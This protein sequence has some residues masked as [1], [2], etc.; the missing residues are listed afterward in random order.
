MRVVP[1]SY[2]SSSSDLIGTIAFMGAPTVSHELLPNGDE[3]FKSV[4]IIESYLSKNIVGIISGEIGGSNGLM[5]LLVAARKDILCLDADGM[6]R[7]FPCLSQFLPFINGLPP[8]PSCLCDVRGET[9]IGTKDMIST[10]Q[11]LEDFFRKECTQRG[12]SVGVAFPP[13]IGKQLQDHVVSYSLS[14]AW[15][16]GEYYLQISYFY[17][18]HERYFNVGEAKF[19]HRTNAIEAV[20]HAGHGR[21]LVSDGKVTNVER[22]TAAG[23]VRGHVSIETNG[24]TLIIEFQNENLLARY[25]DG[26]IVASTPDIITLV[27]Q[28]SA[29][30]LATEIVKY[31]YRVSVLVL[32]VPESMT[33]PQALNHVGLQAFKYNLE[34]YTYTPSHTSIKSVW[35]V[36]Y[37]KNNLQ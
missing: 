9:V 36:F 37:E 1:P 7:A 19:N 20:A 31:G 32:P 28:D 26:E 27:E 18:M 16:L 33:T 25:N 34:N 23:F 2:F 13:I 8:T 4:S 6:G 29:E 30:P 35:D 21:V 11:E 10:S 3:C 12:L 15:F 24:R 5:G 17:Y 14:R 22:H